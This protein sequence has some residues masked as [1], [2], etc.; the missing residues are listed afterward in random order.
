[1]NIIKK[2][3]YYYLK[4]SIKKDRKTITKEKYLGNKIPINIDKIKEEFYRE[5]NKELFVKLEKIKENFQKEWSKIP[6][7]AKKRELEEISIAFTYNT[8]AIEGS[9]ITLYE[10]REILQH[11]FAPNKSL[12]DIEETKRHAKFFLNALK[13]YKPITKKLLLQWHKEIF[14]E[15]KEDI[16]GVFRTY[17]VRV[18]S[19]IA[20]HEDDIISYLN[21]MIKYIKDSKIH[22]VE[23][24]GRM[25]YVFEKI[26]PFGDGNGRI[27]R[28]LMNYILWHNGYPMVIIEKKTRES[29]YKA[30]TK[31]EQNF[32]NYFIKKYL[33]MH[34]KRYL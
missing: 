15:S 3:N 2:K 29:Y 26:H 5:V 18:G 21:Q 11:N 8:N 31:E 25:H 30:L 17:L 22:P 23:L 32:T 20:P 9:T 1:M 14:I 27:G 12:N 19:Y 28:L 10:T 4:Y 16:A 7:S 34:E 33:K 6:D 13:E 24:A